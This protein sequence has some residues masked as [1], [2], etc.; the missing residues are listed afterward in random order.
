MIIN[1]SSENSQGGIIKRTLFTNKK[2]KIPV[3]TYEQ[4]TKD[5]TKRNNKNKS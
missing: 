1:I 2:K 5:E 3:D 4:F